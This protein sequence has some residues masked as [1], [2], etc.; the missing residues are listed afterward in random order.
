MLTGAR[1]LINFNVTL[2]AARVKM[3][4]SKYH[5]TVDDIQLKIEK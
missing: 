3:N 2:V 1:L 5:Q 4:S